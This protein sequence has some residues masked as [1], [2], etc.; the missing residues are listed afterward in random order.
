MAFQPAIERGLWLFEKSHI[1][2][3]ARFLGGGNRQP[4]R[5][6]IEGSR[7]GNRDVLIIERK[8]GLG[9]PAVP[10]PPQIVQNQCRGAY[11]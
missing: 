11:R 4:L 5:R 6:R 8:P 7:D 1:A 10:D 9:K 2:G 3:E